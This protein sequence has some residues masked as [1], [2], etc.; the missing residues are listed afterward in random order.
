MGENLSG[1]S[2]M[3]AIVM[4][5]G[6]HIMEFDKASRDSIAVINAIMQCG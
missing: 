6:I 5:T 4:L 2:S 1:L 3:L